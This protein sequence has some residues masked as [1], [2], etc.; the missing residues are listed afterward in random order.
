MFPPE[1]NFYS[2]VTGAGPSPS[3][4]AAETY[5]AHHAAMTATVGT[6][7]AVGA[8]T[9][10]NYMGLG[11]SAS[12]AA[13]VTHNNEHLVFAEQTLA[14]AQVMHMAA[15][16]HP[17]TVSQMV[18]APPAHAN[19]FEEAADEVINPMVWGALTPRIA[20]LNLEYFGFMWPNNSGAGLRYG[21]TL[22][23]LGAALSGLSGLPSLAGGSVAAP[24]MAAADVAGNAG[25]TMASTVMSATEQAATAVISPATSGGSQ[26]SSL[27]GQ[28]PLLAPSTST[29]TSGISPLA[30]VQSHG[31][32]SPSLPQ[33]QP[34]A[35]GMFAPAAAAALTPSAPSPAMPASPPVQTMAPAA[36][37][38]VT[39]F[40]KPAEPFNSPPPPSGGK[41]AGL[42]P[43]MLN[44]SAL[45]GPVSTMALTTGAANTGAATTTQPLAYVTPDPTQPISSPPPPRPPLQNSGNIQTLNP[46]SQLQ[47]S[48]PHHS[49]PQ[50][51][52]A[53]NGPPQGPSTGNG[54]PQGS[55]G[56]GTQTPGP[57]IGGAPQAPTPAVP[58]DTRP[59]PIPPRPSPGEPPLRPPSPPS[60]ASP[61]VPQ[62]VQAAQDQLKDL[63]RLIQQHNSN[64]PDPSNWAAVSDY[65]AEANYYNSWAAQLQ[66]ELNS[67]QV[68]STPS[69]TAKT[70][71][72]PSWTQPAPQQPNAPTAPNLNQQATQIGQDVMQNVP[73]G[74][75]LN[76]LVDRL[77][78]LHIGNQQQ[79]AEAAQAAGEGAWGQTGGIVN[80]PNGAKLVLPADLSFRQ[81][82]LVA[83]D[84]TLS[85]YEGDLLQFLP[86]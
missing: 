67:S 3:L 19:R 25:I 72:T 68:Q 37:P 53:G 15:A 27:V 76:T 44:A 79:A 50:Q 49:P 63:E 85:V 7:S 2:M 45:R 22:D 47:T 17:S 61:P 80:G 10:E 52:P 16:A 9:A 75:R 64:P 24:A 86:R 57:G 73:K 4:A 34:P 82:I 29:S 41:A 14:R 6:S 71:Q 84:G 51:P 31:S 8:V 48:P 60:W 55:G 21:A 59:P 83:P 62:S 77:S 46:P 33:S 39:S 23:A 30:A 1:V 11:G 65:N 74:S 66:G 28:E 5:V 32:V 42:A 70:A 38:G 20:D 40:A 78:Q 81:A 54:G 12:A 35:M 69:T 13:L 58:L 26:A 36:A 18:P 43:G 56:T